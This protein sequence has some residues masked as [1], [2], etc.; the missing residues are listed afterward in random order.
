MR[1]K[2]DKRVP[3]YGDLIVPTFNA[4]KE[5]GGSGKNDEILDRIIKDLGITDEVAEIAHKGRT[6]KSELSYQADWARTYLRIYGVIENSARAVWAI[7]PD[8]TSVTDLDPKE[9][10]RSRVCRAARGL[11]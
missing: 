7:L 1:E 10:V 3:R 8:Y 9:I 6:D 11:S 2:I 4:L 5:L